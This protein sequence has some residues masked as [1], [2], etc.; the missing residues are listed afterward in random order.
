MHRGQS[1]KGDRMAQDINIKVN[2][3]SSGAN[4]GL[5]QI[6]KNLDAVAESTQ[7]AV[8]DL[9][10]GL[11][12][13][14]QSAKKASKA[15]P[16]VGGA[17]GK[18]GAAA[19]GAG[20]KAEQLAGA[21]DESASSAGEAASIMGGFAGA[22]AVVSP[23]L[24]VL[25]SSLGAPV[26][27]LEAA[28]KASARMA[29]VQINLLNVLGP[30]GVAI[31]A[32]A[33]AWRHFN[34]ELEEAE[35]RMSEAARKAAELAAIA[36]RVKP[37]QARRALEVAV[38]RGEAHKAELAHF[39]AEAKAEAEFKDLK[40]KNAEAIQAA[41]KKLTEAETAAEE[42]SQKRNALAVEGSKAYADHA[43]AIDKAG[44]AVAAES[45]EVER[46][47][48]QRDALDAKQ[49]AAKFQIIE[50]GILKRKQAAADKKRSSG[51][52]RRA[53]K[54]ADEERQ[55]LKT[56]D[57]IAAA[58]RQLNAAE[59]SAFVSG[60]EGEE[61]INAKHADRI[62]ALKK[63]AGAHIEQSQVAAALASAEH[64]AEK[65]RIKEIDE[66]RKQ[67][68]ADALAAVEQERQ[69]R[70]DAHAE[71]MAREREHNTALR[72]GL[73]DLAGNTSDLMG[74][75][76]ENIGGT[77]KEQAR[78]LFNVAKGLSI[79]RIGF[80][81]AEGLISA[82][83]QPPPINAIQFGAVM[84]QSAAS[85]A[86]V[87]AQKPTFQAGSSF[88]NA[89]GQRRELNAKLRAGEAVSTPLGAEILGRGNIER[90]NAGMSGGSG[91]RPG[92]FQYEHRMFSRFIRDNVRM[93]G[94]I[95]TG[96]NRGK[97]T[98]HRG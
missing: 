4:Q 54:Q 91:D 81:T 52:S 77:N 30:V 38:L 63:I 43:A 85:L 29:S 1:P 75:I 45:K 86:M 94:P 47:I 55:R 90:A 95:S 89:T 35:D 34:T 41:R 60:L 10:N 20:K 58:V 48:K 19:S 36:G 22:L 42:T 70:A 37:T 25:A 44:E 21:L 13:V 69:R 16:K 23:R 74:Q 27:G 6:G 92:V 65:T 5:Q 11:D 46:L 72:M 78:A 15:L 40:L 26:S 18:A 97:H 80:S 28:Y 12:G 9:R 71:S 17:A 51:G 68:Q 66:L 88:I 64:E 39:D 32:G 7:G 33:M 84:A 67:Q 24:G 59:R 57:E 56:I 93:R 79:A 50:I 82:A 62:A 98:G 53:K 2:V 8:N 87:A 14:E 76:S 83:S 31:A 3:D 73:Q 96:L 61:A 49:R